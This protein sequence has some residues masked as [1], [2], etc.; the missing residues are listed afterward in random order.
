MTQDS[1]DFQL[2]ITV[3]TMAPDDSPDWQIT[4]VGPGGVSVGGYK[5]LTGPGQTAT[6]GDLTQAGGFTVDDSEGHGIDLTSPGDVGVQSNVVGKLGFFGVPP[7]YQQPVPTTLGE[8]ISYLQSY[9][10]WLSVSTPT[11]DA[12]GL[13]ATDTAGTLPVTVSPAPTVGEYLVAIG[14][15]T[16]IAPIVLPTGFT[17]LA[18]FAGGSGLGPDYLPWITIGWRKVQAGDPATWDFT[19][20][21]VAVSMNA[22]GYIFELAPASGNFVV[23]LGPAGNRTTP[24]FTDPVAVRANAFI[25][26]AV[27]SAQPS[28][29][30]GISVNVS[31]PDVV[32]AGWSLV[33]YCESGQG[34]GLL[35]VSIVAAPSTG[36]WAAGFNYTPQPSSPDDGAAALVLGAW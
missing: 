28:Q 9:G 5:S 36:N 4:A 12:Q 7:V 14:G 10:L 23:A 22:G 31:G 30:M 19:V 32:P 8:V 25:M 16:G 3:E 11:I 13:A 26:G 20:P 18:T 21:D 35:G 15:S 2:T 27:W 24:V 6:P 17:E 33:G 1:P 29:P 34:S